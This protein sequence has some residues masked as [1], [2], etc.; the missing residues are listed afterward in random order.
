MVKGQSVGRD[1]F[2][3]LSVTS[4]LHPA[5]S[6][7]LA[8]IILSVKNR[9]STGESTPRDNAMFSYDADSTYNTYIHH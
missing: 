7:A 5:H 2:P 3:G 1:L 4:T 6:A 8:S 9:M